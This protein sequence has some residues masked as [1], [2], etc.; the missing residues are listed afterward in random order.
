[1][2]IAQGKPALFCFL[3]EDARIKPSDCGALGSTSSQ[4][5]RPKRGILM[6]V[7]PADSN[8]TTNAVLY[9]VHRLRTTT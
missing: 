1:M 6:A 8:P 3:A 7:A 4:G 5:V 2:D 9:L